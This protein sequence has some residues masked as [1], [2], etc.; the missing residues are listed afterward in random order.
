MKN[1]KKT[2]WKQA[3]FIISAL[4]LAGFTA[5]A[6]AGGDVLRIPDGALASGM[7]Q[8]LVSAP[9]SVDS[10]TY[11][12]ASLGAIGGIQYTA[13][14][15]KWAMGYNAWYTALAYPLDA[16]GTIGAS[17]KFLG[18]AFP[19]IDPSGNIGRDLHAESWAIT[20]GFGKSFKGKNLGLNVKYVND[21]YQ[22][23]SFSS[24]AFDAGGSTVLPLNQ[25][26]DVGLGLAVRNLGANLG[27]SRAS[28][29]AISLPMNG[30]IGATLILKGSEK[31]A[32]NLTAEVDSTMPEFDSKIMI[33]AEYGYKSVLFLR[34]GYAKRLAGEGT[35]SF[36]AGLKVSL[37]K[38]GKA[39]KMGNYDLLAN[40]GGISFKDQF[41][42]YA[43]CFSV[44]LL[45]KPKAR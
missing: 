41:N 5:D 42:Q 31:N 7:A 37:S 16:I 23:Y 1:T 13:M 2:D 12:P 22:N 6:T 44:S 30:A 29:A 17:L 24:I 21:M 15:T 43:L 9:G 19:R 10:I 45:E 33:A 3:A 40:F 39:S 36:G 32:F 4:A 35:W 34:G 18:T 27:K 26:F 11:N 25:K 20:A 8:A 28:A 38:F 14:F